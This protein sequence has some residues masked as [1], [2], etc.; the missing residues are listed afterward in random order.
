MSHGDSATNKFVKRVGYSLIVI[1]VPIFGFGV[2]GFSFFV[3][4]TIFMEPRGSGGDRAFIF[5]MVSGIAILGLAV[6]LLGR[7]FV[8]LSRDTDI[9][10]LDKEFLICSIVNGL[11]GVGLAFLAISFIIADEGGTELFRIGWSLSALLLLTA[12]FL[13]VKK[14]AYGTNWL[15]MIGGTISLP[16]GILPLLLGIRLGIV[17][18]RLQTSAPMNEEEGE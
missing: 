5:G 17:T 6:F 13:T 1:S 14:V 18:K 2:I 11:L 8:R 3:F 7:H 10:A 15:M 16:I 9:L 12:L 4:A